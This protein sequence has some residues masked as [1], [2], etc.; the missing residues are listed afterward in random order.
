[1]D[2]K[3]AFRLRAIDQIGHATGYASDMIARGLNHMLKEIAD[4]LV[5]WVELDLP[6]GWVRR[7]NL[8]SK[9]I[10]PRL[11]LCIFAGNVPGVPAPDIC[12][13]LCAGSSVLCK[14]AHNEPHF[15]P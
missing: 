6:R 9:W 1:L 14:V 3:D 15:G 10:A 7:P 4:H 2:E 8:R 12:G 5:E 11:T 13:A